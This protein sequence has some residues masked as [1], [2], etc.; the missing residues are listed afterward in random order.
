[1]SAVDL[2]GL[3]LGFALTGS[4]CSLEKALV[5]M[6]RIKNLGMEIVPIISESVK[7]TDSR[8]G[9]A[10]QWR[11]V[12]LDA[13]G[14]RKIIDSIP[15]AEPIGPQ[16]LLDIML[17]CP[18]SGNTVAKLAAGITDT[19]VLMAAKAH[20]RSGRPL[21][22]SIATN[23]GLGANAKNIGSLINCK[24]IYFV[25]F[26]QD[27]HLHKPNSLVAELSLVEDSLKNALQGQQSQPLLL[28][29]Y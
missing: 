4:Y 6:G 12:I 15:D 27:D 10:S 20:L 5:V 16:K 24:N 8:F 22:L 28:N 21:V 18:C 2:H 29:P 25:P 1:M 14:S 3:R 9:V 23:D 11:Q 13:S 19:P 26:R 7:N 17:I